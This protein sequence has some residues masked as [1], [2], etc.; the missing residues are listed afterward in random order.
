MPFPMPNPRK[1]G[2]QVAQV[3]PTEHAE[4]ISGTPR[5]PEEEMVPDARSGLTPAQMVDQRLQ[6]VLGS[7]YR[8]IFH[9]QTGRPGNLGRTAAK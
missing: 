6:A 8:G 3:D 1:L 5:R 9:Q 2:A 4:L 7:R